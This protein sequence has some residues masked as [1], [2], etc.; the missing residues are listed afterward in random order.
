M[1]QQSVSNPTIHRNGTQADPSYPAGNEAHD[2]WKQ[3]HSR[4]IGWHQHEPPFVHSVKRHDPESRI[5]HMT[6]IRA[7]DMDELFVKV[8]TVTHMVKMAR[9]RYQDTPDVQASREGLVR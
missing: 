9:R 2:A 7:D 6:V 4:Y 5:E 3:E 8:R 1:T